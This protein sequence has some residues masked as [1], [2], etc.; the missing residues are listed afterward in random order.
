MGRHSLLSRFRTLSG[1]HDR[2]ATGQT[3]L[4]GRKYCRKSASVLASNHLDAEYRTDIRRILCPE[5][6]VSPEMLRTTYTYVLMELSQAAYDE[7][8]G[9]MRAAGY[10]HAFGSDGAID[11]HGLA[12][13]PA[14]QTRDRA[15]YTA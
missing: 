10:D 15:P 13:V 6:V 14:A 3:A 2:D 1:H 12:I 8:A 5:S 4:T 7:I 9:K 11:M